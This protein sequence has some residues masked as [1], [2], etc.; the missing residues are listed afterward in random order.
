MFLALLITLLP[1]P[2][3]DTLKS[4]K[5][6]LISTTNVIRSYDYQKSMK[7]NKLLNQ[8]PLF[9][10]IPEIQ[11]EQKTLTITFVKAL[12][13]VVEVSFLQGN[14]PILRIF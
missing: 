7:M 11:Q 1:L 5:R 10:F 13:T 3:F 14:H 6:H 9:V 8:S 2:I 4:G 12:T